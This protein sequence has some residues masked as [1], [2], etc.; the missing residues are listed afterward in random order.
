MAEAAPTIRADW[1]LLADYALVDQ[2]GKLSVI[3]IF[4]RLWAPTFPSLH[5][6]GF[7]VVA[8]TGAPEGSFNA[9]L[10]LWSPL[11]EIV[12]GGQQIVQLG[13]DGH[14]A[15][16]MRLQPIPLPSPGKYVIE[17]LADG[18]SA[19]QVDLLVEQQAVP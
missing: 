15:G 18:N 5:P 16:L 14:A 12:L 2:T 4:S 17:L 19:T 10:R 6:V 8:W 7:V 11:N 9:E 3:G 1:A 13:A